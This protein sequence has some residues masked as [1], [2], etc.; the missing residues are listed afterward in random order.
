MGAHHSTK[1]FMFKMSDMTSGKPVGW[2]LNSRFW[3]QRSAEGTTGP[4]WP[5]ALLCESLAINV[6]LWRSVAP[7]KW[8]AASRAE[9]QELI[10]S[11]AADWCPDTRRLH[12][13]PRLALAVSISIYFLFWSHTWP[14]FYYALLN[15]CQSPC[16]ND[17]LSNGS[18]SGSGIKV[19][20]VLKNQEALASAVDKPHVVVQQRKTYISMTLSPWGRW[21]AN[22]A[23]HSCLSKRT[24]LFMIT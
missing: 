18:C 17:C 7:R 9:P 8:E 13:P 2:K 16:L 4:V 3:N 14:M 5:R 20:G 19:T 11:V 10:K 23:Q 21:A 24:G 12:P 1:I 6:P 15:S 22:W